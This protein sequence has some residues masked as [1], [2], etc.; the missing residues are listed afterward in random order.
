MRSPGGLVEAKL[1]TQV[2]LRQSLILG[3]LHLHQRAADPLAHRL[4][5]GAILD[6]G[7]QRDFLVGAHLARRIGLVGGLNLLRHK[8]RR[9]IHHH[10][11]AQRRARGPL[12]RLGGIDVGRR[13]CFRRLRLLQIDRSE[14]ADLQGDPVLADQVA[15]E[16]QRVLGH[17]QVFLRFH[18]IPVIG[19]DLQHKVLDGLL[20]VPLRGLLRGLGDAH[21]EGREVPAEVAQQRL[22]YRQRELRNIGR[23]DRREGRVGIRAFIVEGDA[24]GAVGQRGG[25]V[26]PEVPVIQ[27]VGERPAAGHLERRA[28]RHHALHDVV[29]AGQR[30]IERAV[31]DLDRFLAGQ[32]IELGDFHVGIVREPDIDRLLEREPAHRIVARSQVGLADD[33][34]GRHLLG[35]RHL[36]GEGPGQR[37][38]GSSVLERRGLAGGRVEIGRGGLGHRDDLLIARSRDGRQLRHADGQARG[39][40]WRC[41]GWHRWRLRERS[42]RFARER[43]QHQDHEHGKNLAQHLSPGPP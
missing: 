5:R 25:F 1:C 31:G 7:L 13:G 8:G 36:S 21:V 11:L 30:R 4:Q 39:R 27:L 33:A 9:R 22:R 6:R 12:R 43:R 16:P 37:Q 23:I 42:G 18:H 15:V 3:K 35:G 19:A 10:V 24:E 32:R 20:H 29:L 41:G 34:L 17:L 40:R 38:Y 2:E 26:E 14:R 28:D